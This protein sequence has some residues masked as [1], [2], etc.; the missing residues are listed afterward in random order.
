MSLPEPINWQALF[1]PSQYLHN[2]QLPFPN[3]TFPS[4]HAL[5]PPGHVSAESHVSALFLHVPLVL[6]PHAALLPRHTSP[7]QLPVFGVNV[8]SLS[9]SVAVFT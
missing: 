6:Y 9:G 1:D 5:V 8:Q 7:V 4:V 3:A 2:V